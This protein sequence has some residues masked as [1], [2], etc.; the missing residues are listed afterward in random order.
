MNIQR[1]DGAY[2]TMYKLQSMHN[3]SF[4]LVTNRSI[5]LRDQT[6]QWLNKNF[7]GIF[8]EVHFAYK[9]TG[10]TLEQVITKKELCN[11]LNCK[12]LIDDQANNLEMCDETLHGLLF[13]HGDCGGYG[14]Y[15]W[16]RHFDIASNDFVWRVNGWESIEDHL[17][18]YHIA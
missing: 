17:M 1:V 9:G 13:S 5:I 2:Q 6:L 11:Q 12:I 3:I 14:T 18:Q 7:E 8:Q 10:D 15:S 16:N 4:H